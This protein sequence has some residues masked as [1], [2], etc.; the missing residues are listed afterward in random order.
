MKFVTDRLFADPEAAARKLL[1]LA[2][3]F[4]P[5]QDGRIYIEKINGP[6]L[7]ELRARRRSTRPASIARSPRAGWSCM[8]AAPTSGSRTQAPR[9]S[10]EAATF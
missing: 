8:R 3:T 2:N 6:F 1:E 10:P 7:Y 9:C 5:I 4:E